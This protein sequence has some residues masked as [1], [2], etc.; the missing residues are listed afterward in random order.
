MLL[1]SFYVK[2]ERSFVMDKTFICDVS[3][4]VKMECMDIFEMQSTL[5]RLITLIAG[6]NDILKEE[7]ELYIRLV[8][9]YKEILKKHNEF[10]SVYVEKYKN[11]LDENKQLSLDFKTNKLFIISVEQ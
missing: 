6:N 8:E 9:D 5:E 7:S 2:K 1:E 3:E 4:E 11:L 10:W